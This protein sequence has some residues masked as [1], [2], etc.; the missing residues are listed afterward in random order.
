MAHLRSRLAILGREFY[1]H[2]IR[3]CGVLWSCHPD[4]NVSLRAQGAEPCDCDPILGAETYQLRLLVV[5]VQLNLRPRKVRGCTVDGTGRCVDGTGCIERES[6]WYGTAL[7]GTEPLR[8]LVVGID[9]GREV[10]PGKPGRGG[11]AMQ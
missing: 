10:R 8:C 4:L 11:K 5:W 2:G 3:Q 6:G 1:H 9:C 7:Y